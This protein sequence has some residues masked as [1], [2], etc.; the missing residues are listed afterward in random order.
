MHRPRCGSCRAATSSCRKLYDHDRCYIFQNADGRIF[1]AIPY[2]RD[3]TLIGTTDLDYH[4]DPGDVRISPQEIAYLCQGASDYFAHAGDAGHGGVDLFRRAPA[5]RR[6]RQPGAG[7]DAGLRAD[8]RTPP[9]GGPPLLNVFGGKIT[10]Y[11]RLAESALAKL[12]AASAAR[13]GAAGE[14]DGERAAARRR[15]PA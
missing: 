7:G 15:F 13:D 10:T 14:L 8:G 4:G 9:Q 2:E 5:L 3:F 6:R 12:D 11:R 1:F